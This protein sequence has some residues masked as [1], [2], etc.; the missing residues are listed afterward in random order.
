MIDFDGARQ[1]R[2]DRL[3][4]D[5]RVR[6]IYVEDLDRCGVAALLLE[7]PPY[8]AGDRVIVANPLLTD[9]E[10]ERAAEI[11]VAHFGSIYHRVTCAEVRVAVK[12]AVNEERS[13]RKH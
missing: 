10:L 3:A 1:T 4:R 12:L 11:C 5:L 2:L 9:D 6:A 13:S 7:G 8:I